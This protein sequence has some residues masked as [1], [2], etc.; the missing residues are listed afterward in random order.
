MKKSG[1]TRA[2]EPFK[3]KDIAYKHTRTLRSVE[4]PHAS[5]PDV[6]HGN[7]LPHQE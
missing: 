3:M 1:P 6:P 7:S 4:N 5:Q 2:V